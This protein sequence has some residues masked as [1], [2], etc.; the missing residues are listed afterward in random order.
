MDRD[1]ERATSL[2][3]L[4]QIR[5]GDQGAWSRTV[6]LYGPLVVYWCRRA[7]GG[8]ESEDL[9]QE[10]LL[11]AAGRIGSFR[12]DRPG[13]SFRGWLRAVARNKI[14]DWQRRRGRRVDFAVG[15][16]VA[17]QVLGEQADPISSDEDGERREAEALYLRALDLVRGEFEPRTWETFLAVTVG[18]KAAPEV[19]KELGV[20][21]AAVR[22]AKSRVLRR[23]KEVVGDLIE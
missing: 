21:S 19:A 17:G 18:G 5:A 6:A 10:V 15:G 8:E 1:R 2:T 7:G 16:T 23:L 9:A 20:T 22:L 12:R 3:L 11:S 13:D 4:D 14:L